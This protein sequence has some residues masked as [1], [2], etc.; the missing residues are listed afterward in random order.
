MSSIEPVVLTTRVAAGALLLAF[1]GGCDDGGYTGPCSKEELAVARE[2]THPKGV[3]VKFARDY[4]G[5]CVADLP[6][7]QAEAALD[8]YR[9]QL[10][11]QGWELRSKDKTGVVK[12]LV[13]TDYVQHD[14]SVPGGADEFR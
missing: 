13:A 6:E 5:G 2:V 8:H 7:D 3:K 11:T 4:D 14:K 1:A 12:E 10:P 9:Q